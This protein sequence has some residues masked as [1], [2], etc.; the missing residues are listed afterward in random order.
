M[1]RVALLLH[2]KLGGWT[3]SASV[4]SRQHANC[5]VGAAYNRTVRSMAEFAHASIWQHVVLAN[6]AA[7]LRLDVYMHSWNPEAADLLDKLYSPVAS[8]H[9]PPLPDLD[10]LH[11]QH[12][13]LKR[14]IALIDEASSLRPRA[15]P[16]LVV[17]ARFDLI[18]FVDLQL[19]NLLLTG[20]PGLWLPRYCLAAVSLSRE[21]SLPLQQACGCT[22]RRSCRSHREVGRGSLWQAPYSTRWLRWLPPR[23]GANWRTFV[24]DQIFVATLRVARSFVDIYDHTGRYESMLDSMQDGRVRR[25]RRAP[26]SGGPSRPPRPPRWAHFYWAAHI[27]H[28][29]IGAMG[30]RVS[31]LPL[32]HLRD[33]NI[34]RR[35]WNGAVCDVALPPGSEAAT[36]AAALAAQ[37]QPPPHTF[38]VRVW[39]S[40]GDG[41]W[42]PT[43]NGTLLSPGP[44]AEQC[45]AELQR[46]TRVVCPWGAPMC[47]GGAKGAHAR[48]VDEVLRRGSRMIRGNELARP[49]FTP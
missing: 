27:T 24:L 1:T 17:V 41:V 25:R 42:Q 15:Q 35:W 5:G 40:A 12:V 18:F 16:R 2:G 13:S 4:S 48:S 10:S 28:V 33:F 45:P 26:P 46:G 37:R 14:G 36:H 23:D 47:D 29:V 44:L 43:A 3:A 7:G 11:S 9:E 32:M 30:E 21:E 49:C 38:D 8:S 6:R 34:G 39:H 22:D 19:S 20:G 31:F